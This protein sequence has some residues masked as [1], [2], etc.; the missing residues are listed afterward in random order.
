MGNK[1]GRL[2]KLST[3]GWCA[4]LISRA[5]LAW[6]WH[7]NGLQSLWRRRPATDPLYSLR[8]FS[9]GCTLPSFL[10]R[11]HL[12]VLGLWAHAHGTY[13]EHRTVRWLPDPDHRLSSDVSLF[14][15]W[16]RTCE[17]THDAKRERERV[18]ERGLIES[19][20]NDADDART[21]MANAECLGRGPLP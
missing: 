19:I 3:K 14:R 1:G 4:R 6:T 15:G 10:T 9:H 21:T 5:F 11:V 2:V 7:T 17:H 12:V 20:E 13:E 16:L 8:D 18:R